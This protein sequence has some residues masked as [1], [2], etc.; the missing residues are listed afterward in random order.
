MSVGIPGS[1]CK[2]KLEELL[3]FKMPLTVFSAA[4][5]KKHLRDLGLDTGDN[6]ILHSRLISF[7]LVPGGAES[8]FEAL[9]DVVG[10]TATIVVPTYTFYLSETD[11]YDP[12]TTPSENMGVLSE[13]IRQLSNSVR[14]ACPIHNHSCVGGMASELSLI[15]GNVS[16]G[17]GSDFDWMS[18]HEFK[19]VLLGCG[20]DVAGTQAFHSM[21][22]F[23]VPYRKWLSLPRKRLGFDGK[24]SQ[25]MVQYYARDAGKHEDISIP[26]KLLISRNQIKIVSA[27]SGFSYAMSLEHFRNACDDLLYERPDVFLVRDKQVN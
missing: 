8:V 12:D 21:T 13:Y 27:P 16:F 3:E 26:K 17:P 24:I 4:N 10:E 22:G 18:K 20:F 5:F 1:K 11:V 7:G 9:L 6:I 2:E 19:L 23:D 25:V 15:E 14:S